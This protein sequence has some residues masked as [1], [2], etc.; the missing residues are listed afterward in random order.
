LRSSLTLGNA[1]ALT[2][3]SKLSKSHPLVP[4]ICIV[5]HA[6]PVLLGRPAHFFSHAQF[7][8]PRTYLS[9]H[10]WSHACNY[11]PTASEYNCPRS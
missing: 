6:L 8:L 4:T 10:H 11:D 5:F 3:R 7:M 9:S 2:R 1:I